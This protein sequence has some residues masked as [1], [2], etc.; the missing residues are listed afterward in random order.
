MI[1]AENSS[2]IMAVCHQPWHLRLCWIGA[3]CETPTKVLKPA[4]W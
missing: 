3:K 1:F 2:V 4:L